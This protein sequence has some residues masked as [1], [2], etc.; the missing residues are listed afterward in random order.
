[1]KTNAAPS[2][3]EQLNRPKYHQSQIKT[4]LMCGLRHQ[5]RYLQGVRMPGG[6]HATTGS[7]AD[8][9]ISFNLAHKVKTG[10]CAPLS[11]V[12]DVCSTDFDKRVPETAF[13]ADESPGECKDAALAVVKTHTQ[14]LA[15]ALQPKAVQMEFVIETDAG[16]DIGGTLDIVEQDDTLRDTKTASR[17]RASSYVVPRSF[18][19]AMYDYAFTAVTGRKSP[20]WAFDVFTRP[21]KTLPAEYKPVFGR[22]EAADHEW[23]FNGIN[24][25]H[26]A[27]RAGIALPAPE[28]S[29]YCSERWCEFWAICKGKK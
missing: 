10:E 12:L 6:A 28:G 19:P 4:F 29:W 5:F 1:M 26:R 14:G 2:L 18:Q 3:L 7:A 17:Q 20:G 21:T 25:M 27:I 22:V 24:Q 13:K 23:L 11:D 8:T 15:T 9:A 16:F